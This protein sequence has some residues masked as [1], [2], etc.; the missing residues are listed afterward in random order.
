M[1]GDDSMQKKLPEFLYHY[2]SIENLE[3]ILKNKTIRFN[4]LSKVDDLEEGRVKEIGPVG[5]F[6]YVSCW[7]HEPDE[8]IKM[9]DKYAKGMTGVR[10]NLPIKPF[11]S[12]P[13][14]IV[15]DNNDTKVYDESTFKR[16]IV[17]E[18]TI[19]K[20]KPWVFYTDNEKKLMPKLIRYYNENGKR[21]SRISPPGHIKRKCWGYQKAVS[22]THLR[23][24]E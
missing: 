12:E 2:T 5:K 1:R 7:T 17:C 14:I 19:Q 9:W 23:A 15:N 4:N 13:E 6:I 10:I 20:W 21:V 16:R 24:H 22:Y 11:G 3:L 18:F 8:I